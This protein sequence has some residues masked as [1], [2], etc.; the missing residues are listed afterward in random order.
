MATLLERATA[1]AVADEPPP[2]DAVAKL[3]EDLAVAPPEEAADPCTVL[4][5]AGLQR[6]VVVGGAIVRAL[7]RVNPVLVARKKAREG[8]Y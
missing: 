3:W 1:L 2:A 4:V 5:L 8:A 7:A 6:R